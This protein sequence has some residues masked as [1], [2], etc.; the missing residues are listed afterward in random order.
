MEREKR[1]R[2]SFFF[3]L[4]S[5]SSSSFF[6]PVFSNPARCVDGE[7]S[8]LA[9]WACCLLLAPRVLCFYVTRQETNTIFL[10]LPFF[11]SPFRSAEG[12]SPLLQKGPPLMFLLLLCCCAAALP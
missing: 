11:P 6:V 9:C 3:F 5:C 1:L 2:Q 4:S 12:G 8:S 10:V 7:R